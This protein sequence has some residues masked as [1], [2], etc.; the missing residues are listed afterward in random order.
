MKSL[1]CSVC[2]ACSNIK[3]NLFWVVV[4]ALGYVCIFLNFVYKAEESV[5][6]L[7]ILIGTECY[8]NRLLEAEQ[9]V[10]SWRQSK[11]AIR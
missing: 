3:S 1:L 7:G 9:H 4:S 2:Q 6:W 11:K 5:S 10:F 8:S